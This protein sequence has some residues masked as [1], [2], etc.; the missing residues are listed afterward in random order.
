MQDNAVDLSRCDQ[1]PIH[2]PGA[3][4]P[5]G[6]LLVV[7]PLSDV[8]FGAAGPLEAILGAGF[9]R[10]RSTVQ[11]ILGTSLA[12]LIEDTGLPLSREASC[13]GVVPSPA[14]D[15]RLT[16]LAHEA[17]DRVILELLPTRG[18]LQAGRLLSTIRTYGERI[19]QTGNT[20]D[21]FRVAIGEVRRITG[22]DRVLVYQFLADGSGAVVAEDKDEGLP[23]YLNHRFPASDIPLQ[24]RALYSANPIRVIP[25][26][27]YTPSPV[28]WGPGFE[29]TLDMS[30]CMLR[31]VSP[32]HIRYL[33]NMGVQASM[34]VSLMTR[35][36]LWGLIA[37]HSQSPRPVTYEALE[38]CRHVGVF[39]SQ[40]IQA[41]D[42]ADALRE[43]SD[44]AAARD[45]LMGILVA[46]PDARF[47]L[48]EA[49]D[50]LMAVAGAHG[51]A[52]C[53]PDGIFAFG[54]TPPTTA[55]EPL[56]RWVL[57][58]HAG[59]LFST[60]QVV[61]DC[62]DGYDLSRHVSGLL[63]TVLP[64]DE[65]VV[66]LWF[67]AE[68][69]EE[70]EWAGNPH[71]AI[72]LSS[73]SGALTP[74]R[75]FATWR[76]TVRDRA[77]PWTAA[78]IESVENLRPRLAFVFQQERIRDLN[79]RL[80]ESN[81]DLARLAAM[82]GLTGLANRRT[83]DERLRS[84]WASARTPPRPFA[85]VALDIDHFKQF[86]D[87]YGHP[88]GDKC[89]KAISAVI[90][91]GRRAQDLA[92]RIGGEEFGLILPDTNLDGAMIIAER[93]RRQV[94][95]LAIAHEGA[96]EGV[97]TVSLGVHAT[98]AERSESIEVIV[99]AADRA[100]YRAKDQGRNR[101][102]C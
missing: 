72:E 25:D 69:I 30:Q 79:A 36:R 101:V 12:R 80:T 56:S 15:G 77:R 57:T 44:L 24:A 97:V 66:A 99:A 89:L 59:P 33:K 70:I 45:S 48:A 98:P 1:E 83:F 74:R 2:T 52:I 64:L 4:Q 58:N 38:L 6:V 51:V 49:A 8:I 28:T 26:V 3:I 90:G 60:E 88:A 68:Q 53:L 42:E 102:E 95:E 21:A 100:L 39:L 63:A 7:D 54:R 16:V 71:E 62:P 14:R 11:S 55:I 9:E 75:S 65:P 92:A 50:P 13:L 76:E 32:V 86:N 18:D 67:R 34:S 19:G 61:K 82:D 20:V 84:E 31:S 41:A 22:Y 73:R 94:E 17:S 81:R 47:A 46:S 10:G 40:S 37:C 27:G 23:T 87:L 5:Y 85:L 35:G 29:T 96:P 91:T 43:A 93:I 78:E